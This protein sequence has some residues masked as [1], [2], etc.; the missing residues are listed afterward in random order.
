MAK[1][2]FAVEPLKDSRLP[3]PAIERLSPML[4]CARKSSSPI[5]MFGGPSPPLFPT[6]QSLF[7]SKL[8]MTAIALLYTAHSDDVDQSIRFDADQ[9]GAKRRKALSV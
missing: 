2:R 8:D 1:A 7:S 4:M 9:I 5:G 6:P 3:I